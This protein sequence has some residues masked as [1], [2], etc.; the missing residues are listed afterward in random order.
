MCVGVEGEGVIGA[1]ALAYR[2][3]PGAAASVRR[4]QEMGM[5]VV[6]LSGDRQPAVDALARDLGLTGAGDVAVVS[7][8]PHAF[9]T[10]PASRSAVVAA[11]A[12]KVRELT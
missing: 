3:R 12:A 8:V 5:R 10:A 2:I 4:L 1:L 6:V 9:S 11:I 7:G